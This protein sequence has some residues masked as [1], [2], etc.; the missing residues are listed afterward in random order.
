MVI[1]IFFN[2]VERLWTVFQH[3]DS[4]LITLSLPD[5]FWLPWSTESCPGRCVY[6][7]IDFWFVVH[8]I[9]EHDYIRTS[10]CFVLILTISDQYFNRFQQIW[11]RICCFDDILSFWSTVCRYLTDSLTILVFTLTISLFFDCFLDIGIVCL[12][13]VNT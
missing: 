10:L 3:F 5:T 1:S 4:E 13:Q 8:A 6:N 9:V 7:I 12:G 11:L 2:I